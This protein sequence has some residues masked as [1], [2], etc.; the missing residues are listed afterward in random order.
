[1]KSDRDSDIDSAIANMIQLLPLN[2][3]CPYQNNSMAHT[4]N[5]LPFQTLCDL[6]MAGY[7]DYYPYGQS[8]L[9]HTNTMMECMELCAQSHP[10]CLGISWNSAMGSGFGNCYLKNTQNGDPSP[11]SHSVTHLALVRLPSIDT[12]LSRFCAATS[13]KQLKTV[14]Y[15]MWRRSNW[16]Q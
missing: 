7:G 9:A 10:L 6:D 4:S 11:D 1:M 8:Y 15:D 5:G 16:K 2:E 13:I 3:T 12:C 14:Q